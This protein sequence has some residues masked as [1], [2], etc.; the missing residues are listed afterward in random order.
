MTK[1]HHRRRFEDQIEAKAHGVDFE[2]AEIILERRSQ[3]KSGNVSWVKVFHGQIIVMDFRRKFSGRTVVL[4]D[5]KIFNMKEKADM[6]RVGLVDPVFEKAFE[7]YSTDQVEAR[8]LL[9]PTFMQRLVDLEASVKGKNIR[10]GFF[11]GK[12][13]IVIETKNRFESG[14]M[15][16]S[17]LSV[18]KSQKILDEFGAVLDV[19]DGVLEP[20]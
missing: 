3:S 10:F 7:A 11:D 8:Y 19:I 5:K 18:D 15:L 14:S 20:L 16:T 2:M 13:T 12:L 1:N 9:T 17:L 6:K 4:R